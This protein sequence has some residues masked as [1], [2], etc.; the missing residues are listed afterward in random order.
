MTMHRLC[1]L[2][3]VRVTGGQSA[4][5]DTPSARTEGQMLVEAARR[6]SVPEVSSQVLL[7]LLLGRRLRLGAQQAVHAHHEA[8]R[9]E[10][11]LAAVRPRQSLLH[12]VQARPAAADA[13]QSGPRKSVPLGAAASH[14]K[15]CASCISKTSTAAC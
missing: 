4:S 13:C 14:G 8:G 5:E 15:K 10:A 3:A 6:C 2:T 11:A 12:R 1:S 9:A 7:D